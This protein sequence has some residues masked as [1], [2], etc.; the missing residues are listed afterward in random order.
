MTKG[1]DEGEAPAEV[2]APAGANNE[3]QSSGEGPLVPI[4][5]PQYNIVEWQQTDIAE[6]FVTNIDTMDQAKRVGLLLLDVEEKTQ[7]ALGLLFN[8]VEKGKAGRGLKGGMRE[9]A[10]RLNM[11]W[12]TAW[13]LA[14]ATATKELAERSASLGTSK[15]ELIERAPEPEKLWDWHDAEENP[16]TANEIRQEVRKQHYEKRVQQ[17]IDTPSL[18]GTYDVIVIDPPW[19]LPG[20]EWDPLADRSYW[21]TRMNQ[22]PYPEMTLDAIKALEL[23]ANENCV[24][25]LWITNRNI[26]QLGEVLEAWGFEYK[27]LLTWVKDRIGTG[28]WLRGQTEH[29]ALAIKGSVPWQVGGT[30]TVLDAPMW[31]DSQKPDEFY[32]LEAPMRADSQKP[33]EFYTLVDTLCHGKKLDMFSREK[34][35]G[36]DQWGDEIDK[37]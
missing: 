6:W 10:R 7:V 13:G 12:R 26:L 8:H 1:T 37:F 25:W 3:S 5:D 31:F 30:P 22:R 28:Y 19:P 4:E 16:P 2:V 36:W 33:D 17:I 9:L 32:I 15:V 11:P 24:L 23:P 27:T 18:E 14:T 29:C 21:Q 34:R 35:D 20:C